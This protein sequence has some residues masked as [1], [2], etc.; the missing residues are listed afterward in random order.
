MSKRDRFK[1]KLG[2][3]PTKKDYV[4]KEEKWTKIKS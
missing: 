3:I 2:R 1:V 4:P